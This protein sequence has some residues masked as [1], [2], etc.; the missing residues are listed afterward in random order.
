MHRTDDLGPDLAHTELFEDFPPHPVGS[1]GDPA[2]QFRIADNALGLGNRFESARRSRS[3]TGGFSVVG[4]ELSSSQRFYR[5]ATEGTSS[6]FLRTQSQADC[7]A[8]GWA[9][10]QPRHWDFADS[11]GHFFAPAW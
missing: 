8:I 5:L 9:D 1:L 4:I 7:Q 3:I 6:S 10:A 2:V 11:P